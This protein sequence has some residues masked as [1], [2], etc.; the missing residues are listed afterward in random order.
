MKLNEYAKQMPEKQ[1]YQENAEF[2][3][4]TQN[5]KSSVKIKHTTRGVS[6]EIKV[7]SGEEDI[8]ENLKNKALE[9]YNSIKTQLNKQEV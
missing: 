1:D 5:A 6:F 9:Q 4:L 3:P 7:V 8:I 2:D